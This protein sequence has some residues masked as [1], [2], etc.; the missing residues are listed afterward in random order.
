MNLP[1]YF[2]ADLPPEAQLSP[3]MVRD[4]CLT[5]KRNR[6]QY[7]V[8]RPTQ[9]LVDTL[10]EVAAAWLE[11]SDPFRQ[12]A[13]QLGPAATGFSPATLANGLDTFFRQL[14]YDGFHMLLLQDLGHVE[15]LDRLVV[16][17]AELKTRRSAIATGPELLVQ[18][19]AGNLPNPTLMSLILGLLARS[20]QFIKCATGADL[21]PRLLAHSLYAVEPKLASCIEI[22]SWPGGSNQLESA[23][24]EYADC[25]TATGSDETLDAIRTRLP[26]G[27]RFLGYGHR[28]SFGY[29]TREV[30][31]RFHGKELAAQAA[32]DVASW[33]QL[34]CLSPHV[35]YVET[36][37]SVTPELFAQWI[38]EQLAALETKE[39]RALPPPE[40][41]SAIAS[42]RALYAIRA[43]NSQENRLW[44][45]QDSTA[46][47]VVYESDPQ[48]QYS[49]LH[50]FVYVKAV[51]SLSETLQ[52]ASPLQG[53]VSTVSLAAMG[54]RAQELATQLARWGVPRICQVGQMQNPPLCWRHDGHPS[55]GDLV[56]WTDWE[57]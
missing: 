19:A 44:T 37:G 50:R 48:F 52:A 38:A 28:V 23:L 26:R 36:G 13:L 49:I 32:R 8:E 11:P 4:A 34:G 41:A 14:T 51:A 45:S 15:R 24:L 30:L 27:T 2:L 56:T 57:Q 17:E 35:Y 12:R 18:F 25:V 5:L 47:T 46:W 10:C 1:N 40:T 22:A 54:T 31:S 21:L 9:A 20:A 16:H 43:A 42:R 7:L 53:R 3:T 33:D 29:I 55:L 6:Q 39:P